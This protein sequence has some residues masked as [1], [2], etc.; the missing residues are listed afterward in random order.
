M[1]REKLVALACKRLK[2]IANKF[3]NNDYFNKEL[4]LF[5][6]DHIHEKNMDMIVY[7]EL[8]IIN[9]V[10][11]KIIIPNF[12]IEDRYEFTQLCSIW[13]VT[14]GLLIYMNNPSLDDLTSLLFTIKHDLKIINNFYST[15]PSPN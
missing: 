14:Y 6:I 15:V 9:D 10:Y 13:D 7:Q 1:Y 5:L 8:R 11:Q 3:H 2:R 12:T 4:F